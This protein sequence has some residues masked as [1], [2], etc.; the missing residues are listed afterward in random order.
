METRQKESHKKLDLM[1]LVLNI[2]PVPD[3]NF[4]WKALA[5]S[6]C[7][8][9]CGTGVRKRRLGCWVEIHSGRKTTIKSIEVARRFCRKAGLR[10][11]SIEE[12]CETK[13][14]PSWESG[15]WGAC[16]AGD[17]CV[18][19]GRGVQKRSVYCIVEDTVAQD[20]ECD[21]SERPAGTRVCPRA[22]CKAEWRD[23]PW[24]PCFDGL[25]T[26]EVTCQ[27]LSGHKAP[28]KK[29]G[30]LG[31][32]P[33]TLGSCSQPRQVQQRR[34]RGQGAP[35]ATCIDT[36]KF[37]RIVA[38]RGKCDA[39]NIKARCCLTCQRIL[40]KVTSGQ[41]IAVHKYWMLMTNT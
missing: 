20:Q 26:R 34:E 6:P 36:M 5:W 28:A 35:G 22:A 12:S 3:K 39:D 30:P 1:A 7:S 2:C 27:W 11:P 4:S 18:S 25:R 31:S 32:R 21:P 16:G 37:C 10:R 38:D 15:V 41:K 33:P 8:R 29:C 19:E 9:S 17:T 23:G 24:S 40:A 13:R 14:C